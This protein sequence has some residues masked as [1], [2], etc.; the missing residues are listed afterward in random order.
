LIR[1]YSRVAAS[2]TT[3]TSTSIPLSRTREA[4]TA[5]ID[6]KHRFCSAAVLI[7]PNIASQFT[8]EVD[9]S[10]TGVG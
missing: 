7:Q 3:F 9:A 4:E 5:F 2:L 1:N 10:K 8:V 6:L